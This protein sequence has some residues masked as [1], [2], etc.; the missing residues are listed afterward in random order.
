M[1]IVSIY[2]NYRPYMFAMMKGKSGQDHLGDGFS[3][4]GAILV[5]R[6]ELTPYSAVAAAKAETMKDE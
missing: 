3:W 1:F 4:I 2:S 6:S 5:L